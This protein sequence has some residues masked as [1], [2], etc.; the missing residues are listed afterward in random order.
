MA[1][2]SASRVQQFLADLRDHPR[3]LASLDPAKPWYTKGEL[4]AL[5]SVKTSAVPSLVRRHRLE[6]TGNGKAR[7]YPGATAAAL[8]SLRTRGRSI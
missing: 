6:A 2:L 8:R 1:D 5:P 7:R 4:A 3:A